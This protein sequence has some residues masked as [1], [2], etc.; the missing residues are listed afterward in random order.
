MTK[1]SKK[2]KRPLTS[3]QSKAIELV[4]KHPDKTDAEISKDMI[5]LGITGNRS[6]LNITNNRNK[7]IRDIIA[8]KREKYQLRLTNQMPQALKVTKKHLKSNNLKAAA[9]VMKHALPVQ[10]DQPVRQPMI[11]IETLN[12]IQD[13]QL[14]A[15]QDRLDAIEVQES[16]NDNE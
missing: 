12:I 4:T 5:D 7:Q 1:K 2:K 8:I 16:S 10:E 11:N 15:C 3:K 13:N 6:Y 14:T 9:L